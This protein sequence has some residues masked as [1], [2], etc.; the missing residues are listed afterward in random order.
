MLEDGRT[1]DGWND[2][3]LVCQ[4]LPLPST[5]AATNS[6]YIVV[7]DHTWSGNASNGS[8]TKT[9]TKKP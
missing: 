1:R 9:K 5:K 8:K 4:G 7:H 3:L 2:E 6:F